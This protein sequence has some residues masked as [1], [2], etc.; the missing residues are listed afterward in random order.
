M[1]NNFED[2]ME[3]YVDFNDMTKT[4]F[5][6]CVTIAILVLKKIVLFFWG[7]YVAKL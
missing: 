2:H 3:K 5:L 1:K 7:S 6:F 4:N